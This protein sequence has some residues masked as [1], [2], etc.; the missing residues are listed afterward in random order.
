M[1]VPGSYANGFAPRDGQPLYP[2]LWKDCTGA[3]N[4]GLGPSGLILR[5][6]S[7]R[8]NH[9]DLQ[10]GAGFT[11]DRGFQMVAFDGVDDSAQANAAVPSG[12]F[13]V[14]LWV[15][16]GSTTVTSRRTAGNFNGSRG[17]GL[18]FAA[19]AIDWLIY[20][21][22]GNIDN[23]E[24]AHPIDSVFHTACTYVFSGTS[25]TRTQYVSG[26]AVNSRTATVG[27]IA[28]ANTF[29]Q[30]GRYNNAT[31]QRFAGSLSDMRIYNRQ[32]SPQAIAL[33]AMRPGIAYD[34]AP[35]KRSRVI[36]GFKAYWAARKAQIIGGGL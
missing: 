13:T 19:N 10:N 36:G 28:G 21:S 9:A 15:R 7:G 4:P 29:V 1:T 27:S 33:L 31:T 3:W 25:C 11:I 24:G 35:R 2:E 14:S 30:F 32:L 5:D 18:F 8:N 16:V 34:L 6:W 17:W 12:S 20:G 23:I 26:V 22:S